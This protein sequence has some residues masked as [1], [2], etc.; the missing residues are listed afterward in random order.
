MSRGGQGAIGTQRIVLLAV[1]LLGFV[2]GGTAGWQLGLALDGSPPGTLA[3]GAALRYVLVLTVAGAAL[4]LLVLP[5]VSIVPLRRLWGLAR[6]ADARNLVGG[7]LGLLVG[8][9]AAAL[10][11]FPVSFLPD[12]FGRW[13]PAGLAVLLAW[14]GVTIGTLRKDEVFRALGQ[15]R[16]AAEGDAGAGAEGMAGGTGGGGMG[17]P[18]GTA[19]GVPA[20]GVLL[21][22]SA[23]VDGRIV[24]IRLSGF[25]GGSLTLPHFV[26]EELQYLA[27][28]S[29]PARRQRGRRGLDMLERLKREADLTVI[30]DDYP[31]VRGVD[32]KL[33]RLARQRRA[34]IVTTDSNLDRVAGLQGIAVLNVHELGNALRAVVVTGEELT[35]EIA[36]PGRER[37]QGIGFLE[38]G[39]MVIVEEG[40][41]LLGGR[42][43]VEVTRVL[44]TAGGRIVFSRLKQGPSEQGMAEQSLS[45]Q[46]SSE[47]GLQEEQEQGEPAVEG[48]L[49]LG[50]GVP[51]LRVV[52]DHDD[53]ADP[54]TR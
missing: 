6:S 50:S 40:R 26:L 3:G 14:L 2:A 32:S 8:L 19:W 9:L 28:S 5:Y 20:G 38:D 47:Q 30:D 42:A 37:G 41:R 39:T 51:V 36:Q 10:A 16:R 13:L 25:L 45:E 15:S 53:R 48:R 7:S 1:R 52:P 49:G 46:G 21:D 18:S 44:P 29:D 23:V 22:T 27:D 33:I 35:L 17:A 54:E 4:G 43:E 34:A 24:A 12:P 31:A 11:A